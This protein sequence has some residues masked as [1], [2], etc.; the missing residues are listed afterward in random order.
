MGKGS[1]IVNLAI[2]FLAALLVGVGLYFFQQAQA[3]QAAEQAVQ[4]VTSQ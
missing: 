2:T 3:V 4:H 1:G